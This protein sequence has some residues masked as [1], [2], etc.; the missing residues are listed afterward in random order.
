MADNPFGTTTLRRFWAFAGLWGAAIVSIIFYITTPRASG[1]LSVL[2]IGGVFYYRSQ[3]ALNEFAGAATVPEWVVLLAYGILA[4]ALV[5]IAVGVLLIGTTDT[6]STGPSVE[7]LLVTMVAGVVVISAVFLSVMLSGTTILV[8]LLDVV[9]QVTPP[10]LTLSP[11]AVII[12][13]ITAYVP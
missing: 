8:D 13:V 3:V 9:L 7:L 2:Q 1:V 4:A 11:I 10:V 5:G 6:R 12:S